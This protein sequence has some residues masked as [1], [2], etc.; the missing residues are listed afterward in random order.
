MF[1]AD[2]ALQRVSDLSGGQLLRAGLACCAGR[3]E[4]AGV[5]DLDEPTTTSIS[6]NRSGRS[7]F[8]RL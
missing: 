3:P 5:A 6:I 7:G 2:A 1:R 8:A 4:A